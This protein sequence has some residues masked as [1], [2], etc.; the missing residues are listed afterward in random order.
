MAKTAK[1]PTRS[2]LWWL[3]RGIDKRQSF[4]FPVQVTVEEDEPNLYGATI[5]GLEDHMAAM[6][7]TAEEAERNAIELFQA[8][9][10]DALDKKASVS[11]AI[12]SSRSMTADFPVSK[13]DEFFK[14]IHDLDFR[15]LDSDDDEGWR[16]VPLGLA[17]LS[18]PTADEAQ[19]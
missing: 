11:H 6:G 16:G 14:L 17:V 8:T 18:L 3:V 15:E 2:R 1:T 4:V 13:A 10:D 12:G 5:P 7:R 9:V 19:S